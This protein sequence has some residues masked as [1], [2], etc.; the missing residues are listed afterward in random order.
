MRKK[1]K[2]G[3]I[4]GQVEIS[5]NR[6]Y[7]SRRQGSSIPPFFAISRTSINNCWFEVL[8]VAL[9]R[10]ILGNQSPSERRMLCKNLSSLLR[11]TAP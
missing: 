6:L 11:H 7:V 8:G 2:E 5:L 1:K 10:D 4:L 9:S 3:P